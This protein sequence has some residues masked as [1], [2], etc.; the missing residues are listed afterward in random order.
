[1][2]TTQ[3]A[4][5]YSTQASLD[6]GDDLPLYELDG[7]IFSDVEGDCDKKI[8]FSS[9]EIVDLHWRL[10]RQVRLLAD[11]TAPLDEKFEIVRWVFTDRDRD[12]RPFSFVNCLRVVGCSP[13]ARLPFCGLIDPEEVR[14]WIAA[15]LKRWFLESLARLPAFAREIVMRNPEW[16]SEQLYIE[17]QWLNRQIRKIALASSTMRNEQPVQRETLDLFG[18]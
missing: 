11:P 5:N 12:Q 14:D 18:Q 15:N 9:Q 13:Q 10:L 7:S 1:M 8:E 16:V 2:E 4:Q 3:S 6:L 17:P